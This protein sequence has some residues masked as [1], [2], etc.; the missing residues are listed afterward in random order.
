MSN[1]NSWI[2][3]LEHWDDIF[4]VYNIRIVVCMIRCSIILLFWVP[5][6][7]DGIMSFLVLYSC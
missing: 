2:P 3:M 1:Q 4:L 7:S 6:S 5:M